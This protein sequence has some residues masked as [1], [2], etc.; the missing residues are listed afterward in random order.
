MT[1]EELRLLRLVQSILVRNYVD[2]QRVNVDVSGSSVYIEGE[3]HVF[4]YHPAHYHPD[5]VQRELSMKHM[6]LQIEHE[7]RSLGEVSH[8]EM[9]FRNWGRVGVQWVERGGTS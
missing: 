8:V 4:E 7:I 5:R 2:T 1:V 6:L 9:K 3:F